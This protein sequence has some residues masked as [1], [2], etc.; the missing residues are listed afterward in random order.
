MPERIRDDACKRFHSGVSVASGIGLVPKNKGQ[1]KDAKTND[2][3]KNEFSGI[4]KFAP[5]FLIDSVDFYSDEMT[6]YWRIATFSCSIIESS[7][8]KLH[9][10]NRFSPSGISLK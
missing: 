6:I 10:I 9:K 4:R 5:F 8:C 1:K 3:E 7:T 2:H